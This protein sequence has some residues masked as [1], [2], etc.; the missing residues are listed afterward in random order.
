MLLASVALCQSLSAIKPHALNTAPAQTK[1]GIRNEAF[2]FASFH[3]R[4]FD[5]M[6]I[7]KFPRCGAASAARRS[8]SAAPA[9]SGAQQHI[10][11]SGPA[12][13]DLGGGERHD[14]Q[15]PAQPQVYRRLEN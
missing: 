13:D 1:K 5:P 9:P 2:M 4:L 11:C 15:M 6:R 8:S 14:I 12:V 3:I 7:L 10:Y